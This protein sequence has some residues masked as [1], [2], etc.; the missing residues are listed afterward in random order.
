M[1]IHLLHSH[2]LHSLV[3]LNTAFFHSSYCH[4]HTADL[5]CLLNAYQAYLSNSTDKKKEMLL[6][7]LYY[8]VKEWLDRF[9]TDFMND[10]TKQNVV[11]FFKLLMKIPNV[12]LSN[13]VIAIMNDNVF[14]IFFIS[15]RE[16]ERE[17]EREKTMKQ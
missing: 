14:A 17:R 8:L 13:D 1:D 6:R 4:I 12:P 10:E 2:L 16:R 11:N 3:L 9:F 5:L 7:G 15:F